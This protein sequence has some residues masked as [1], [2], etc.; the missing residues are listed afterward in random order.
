MNRLALFL[1]ASLAWPQDLLTRGAAVFAKSCATGYCHGL[2]GA[3][4]GAPRLA[5]RGFDEAHI[6]NVTS[7]GVPGTAMQAFASILPERDLTAVVAYVASLNGITPRAGRTP[8]ADPPKPSLPPEAARGRAL[9]F[10]STRGLARCSTCHQ[11]D[12][13]GIPVAGPMAKIPGGV[14]ELRELRTPHVRMATLDGE[15]FPALIVTPGSRRTTFYDLTTPPPVLRTVDSSELR[16][17]E[18]AAWSHAIV[19]GSYREE[20]LAAILTFL[21]AVVRP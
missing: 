9:F 21:R 7:N 8:A 16:I 11:V 3:A 2:K 10:D 6:S 1:L 15:S 4:A 5:A 18:T 19:L 12:G 17:G 20:E 13:F 14:P